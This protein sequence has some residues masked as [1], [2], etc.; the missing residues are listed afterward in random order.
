M[1]DDQQLKPVKPQQGRPLY[2]TVKEAVI[3]AIDA[4]VFRAGERIPSTKELSQQLSVSLVT[5][6]RALQ[7]L[8]SIGILDRR[9]GRGTFV[10]DRKDRPRQLRRIGVLF[11]E[12]ASIADYYHGQVLEGIRQRSDDSLIEPTILPW[13]TRQ[14]P[15]CKGFLLINPPDQHIEELSA[16]V[17]GRAPMLVIGAR[18]SVSTIASVGIDNHDV[19]R[20]AVEYLHHLGHRR[21]AYVGGMNDLSDTRDRRRGFDEICK[22]L[23]I[24]VSGDRTVEASSWRLASEDKDR[25]VGILESKDRPT[26]IFAAGY[27]LALDVY[28][29][30]GRMNLRVPEDL[31]VVAVDDPPSAEHL[32]PRLTTIHQ[33][34]VDLGRVAVDTM[35]RLL[36]GG[37][38]PTVADTVLRTHLI[39]RDSASAPPEDA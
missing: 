12:Q 24:A 18:S 22:R 2:E 34:L 23:D 35:V 7:D 25:L 37:S 39:A 8:V 28:E 13:G 10:I 33:P 16:E 29:V 21:I 3:A 4:G 20:Q 30:A 6:H 5:A 36:D 14:P 9:Q 17:D 19:S 26:A 15:N 31:S 1:T 27:Y 32:S 11:N 38:M